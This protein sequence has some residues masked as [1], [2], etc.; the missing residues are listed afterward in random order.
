MTK[1]TI[2]HHVLIIKDVQDSLTVDVDKKWLWDVI[3]HVID[4]MVNAVELRIM[5]ETIIAGLI[6]DLLTK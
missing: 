1:E 4:A 2:A 6:Q 3:K 5:V